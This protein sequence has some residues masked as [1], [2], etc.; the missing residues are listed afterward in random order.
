MRSFFRGSPAGA[1]AG[2]A[3]PPAR[4]TPLVLA[5]ALV[6]AQGCA[7]VLIGL[8]F[9]VGGLVGGPADVADAELIGVLTLVTAAGLLVAA[10]GLRRA[11]RGAR[12]PA[13]VWQLIMLG[14]GFSELGA[15]RPLAVSLLLVAGLT[16]AALL[17]PAANAVLED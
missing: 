8:G 11:R 9:I 7:G 16:T 17:H 6:A 1:A 14:T 3:G 10:L 13:L 15:N 12:A 4:P 2:A 5:V